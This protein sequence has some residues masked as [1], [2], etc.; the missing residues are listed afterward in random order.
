MTDQPPAHR[1][2]PGAPAREVTHT[3]LRAD[4]T[5]LAAGGDA[6]EEVDADRHID[7]LLDAVANPSGPFP[8]VL[9][10]GGVVVTVTSASW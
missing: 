6:A 7:W 3:T 8:T 9:V 10:G 5:L 1:D 2:G 4:L